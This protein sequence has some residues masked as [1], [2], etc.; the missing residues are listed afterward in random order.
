MIRRFLTRIF[1][2][3]CGLSIAASAEESKVG[4][5]ATEIRIG[6]SMPYSGPISAYGV[7]GKAHSAYFAK[8]NAEGGIN[9]R[10]IKLISLD[11]G[12]NP[13]K[14]LENARRLVEQDEVFILFNSVGTATNLAMRKYLNEKKVPHLFVSG[15]DTAWG[16]HKNY[17]WTLGWMPSYQFEG[18]TYARHLLKTKPNA[19]VALFYSNDDYGK[20]YVKGF[21]DA[22]G[23]SAKTMIVAEQTFNWSDPTVNTQMITLQSSRADTLFS[24]MAGKHASMAIRKIHELGWRPLHYTGVPSASP[25]AILAPAGMERATGLIT[26]YYA[27]DHLSEQ[28]RDDQAIKD[29]YAWAKQYFEGDASDGIVTF[30]YQL[31]QA[32]EY[33]LRKAGNDLTRENVMRIATNMKDV[34]FPMLLPGIRASTTPN[35]YYPIEQL[36]MMRFDGARW[37]PFGEVVSGG[38]H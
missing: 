14:A 3:S 21:V 1:V 36:Q 35:D 29:Y 24:A 15:G 32:L 26:A 37:I 17:P 18:R 38:S 13:G 31:A 27:K 28:W 9:G 23:A 33:V 10:K 8:V 30:G 11:D 16:D 2:V 20:D 25:V 22:L 7:I 5:T 4:V 12:Y 19:K 6:Q 34:E